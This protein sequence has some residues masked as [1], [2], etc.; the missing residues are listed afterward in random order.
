LHWRNRNATIAGGARVIGLETLERRFLAH[1][2]GGETFPPEWCAQGLVGSDVGL[3]IYTN[4][5]SSRLR[6]AL[7]ADHPILAL[8][9]GD[10]LWAEFC[11]GYI[12]AHPSRVR[13]LRIFGAQ[14]PEWLRC[15]KPFANH[16]AISELAAF[17][18]ELL[19]VFD[20]ADAERIE[21][22]IVQSLDT[23]AWPGLR[24][25]FHPSVR[26]LST[27]TNA[28]EIWRAL[29]D[30]QSP[31]D[32]RPSITP[33]HMLWRDRQRISRFRPADEAELI[34]VRSF[35]SAQ[36]DFATVCEKMAEICRADEVPVLA[37]GFLR[38]WFDEGLIVGVANDGRPSPD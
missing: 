14:V 1:V 35:L 24:L 25:Q 4:A 5:Y 31:P 34:A 38:R 8:Y 10:M 3:S 26:L 20:A 28:V 9:L 32:S 33:A 13:S 16:P 17:E 11:A 7:E 12:E 23:A 2:R 29:K 36:D 27:T 21:W 6:E 22:A 37:I 15:N 18:R 19:D 30:E